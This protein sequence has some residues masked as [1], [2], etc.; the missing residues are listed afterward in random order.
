MLGYPVEV[1][2]IGLAERLGMGC[3]R[4]E[5]SKI[6]PRFLAWVTWYCLL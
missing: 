6:F 4:T 5:E 2:V 3:R 1:E